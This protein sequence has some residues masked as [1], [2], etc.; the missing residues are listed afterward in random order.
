MKGKRT[1][2]S[3]VAKVLEGAVLVVLGVLV[4]IYGGGTAVDI[5]FGIISLV[6]GLCLLALAVVG[7]SQKKA[8]DVDGLLVGSILTTVGVCLF[9]PWLSFAALIDLFII[10]ILG[11]G[12]GLIFLGVYTLARKVLFTGLGEIVIGILMV[13]FS[14][15][16]KVNPDFHNVFWIVVGILIAVY[17]ALVIVTALLE[18]GKKK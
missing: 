17:G 10:I 14:I 8:L 1:M 5:Y 7:L 11:L 13:T 6:A 18:K 9:T 12:I 2:N 3:K 16:Y 4:A 15:I